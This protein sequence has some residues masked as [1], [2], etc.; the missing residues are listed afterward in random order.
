M[1][2]HSNILS[3]KN[4]WAEKPSGLQFMGL[5]R[6]G[7]DWVTEIIITY[8]YNSLY[9]LNIEFYKLKIQKFSLCIP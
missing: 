6:I 1:A 5:Q 3:C 2:T 4:Q 9:T 8:L 7:H